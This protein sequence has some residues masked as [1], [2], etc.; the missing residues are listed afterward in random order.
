MLCTRLFNPPAGLK[1]RD[2]M[3]SSFEDIINIYRVGTR[4]TSSTTEELSRVNY[5]NTQTY[6]RGMNIWVLMTRRVVWHLPFY[7]FVISSFYSMCHSL[8]NYYSKPKN[9]NDLYIFNRTNRVSNNPVYTRVRSTPPPPQSIDT[10]IAA[11][12]QYTSKQQQQ[13]QQ[14]SSV[15]AACTL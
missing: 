15:T 2:Y 7:K 8:H 9:K 6:A 5:N 14:Q 11:Y 10:F 12:T 1:P 13:Q 4:T 3:Y